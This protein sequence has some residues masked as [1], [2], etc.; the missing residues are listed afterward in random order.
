M[1]L[2]VV[3]HIIENLTTVCPTNASSDAVA[4]IGDD[5]DLGDFG[6]VPIQ[7][8][9]LITFIYLCFFFFFAFSPHP[10]SNLSELSAIMEDEFSHLSILTTNVVNS[11]KAERMKTVDSSIV[12]MKRPEQSTQ[13]SLEEVCCPGATCNSWLC[14]HNRHINQFNKDY[15]SDD[16]I[17]NNNKNDASSS[18][19]LYQMSQC[20]KSATYSKSMDPISNAQ[21]KGI[22][23]LNTTTTMSATLITKPSSAHKTGSS[24]YQANQKPSRSVIKIP[25]PGYLASK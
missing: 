7:L 19:K 9:S 22:R 21:L 6:N 1:Q 25:N 4:Y 14:P 12:L 3:S 23:Q 20:G 16:I 15:N 24:D 17:V 10:N 2:G 13:E 8:F 18:S 11:I 5:I